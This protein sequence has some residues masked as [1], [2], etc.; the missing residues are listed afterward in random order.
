MSLLN[1]IFHFKE[2]KASIKNEIIGGLVTFVAMCYILPVNSSILKDAG[3]NSAG[4][5][6]ITA[7]LSFIVTWIMGIVAN[8]PVVL[9]AGMGLN[10]FLAYT[11]CGALGFSWQ[12]A[13]I[14][15]TVSGI[16]FFII[17]LTPIRK[18]IIESIPKDLKMII[19]ASLGAFICFVGLRNSGVII[20]G[21]TLVEM[22]SF[23]NPSVIISMISIFLCFGLMFSKNKIVKSLAVPLSILFAAIVGII[24]SEI[25]LASN[26]LINVD[27]SFLYTNMGDALN[28]IKTTLPLFPVHTG[29]KFMDFSGVKDVIFYGSL[30]GG[31][32][33]KD[34][35]I[36]VFTSPAS[37]VAIFSLI[38]VNLFD[39]TATLL[40]IG[41]DTGIIDDGGKM[42]KNYQRAIMADATGALIC[43]PFGTS[44]MTSF[45]ESS[46]GVSLG[47]K[48]GFAA[49]ISGLMFLLCAF[50]YP[51]FSIFTAGSVTC[52]ALV[53]VGAMIFV[54]NF[55]DI[56]WKE[57]IIGFTAFLTVVFSLLTYSI[58]KGIGIGLIVYIVMNLFS[59]RAKEIKL[60]IYI[61]A[62]LFIISFIL[63]AILILI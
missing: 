43:G 29:E 18:I 61:I 4:V 52:S 30:S 31:F 27:G 22:S 25:L 39:T 42:D 26:K 53:S 40:T 1:K 11:I 28:N 20:G 56:N 24:T 46:V 5:F 8:Y 14:L 21:S 3:M 47:A 9:S 38:F 62:L 37:Y 41:K 55:K 13:L 36:K 16:I 51:V 45:A 59:K 23:A 12:E 15:L 6:I 33:L 10:A 32:N 49:C 58:A 2:K 50:I 17:S 48:T 57:P 44:T 35:L 63:D 19:S 7:I 34:S 54:N 60:P